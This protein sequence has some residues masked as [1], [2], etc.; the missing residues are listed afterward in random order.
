MSQFMCQV[1]Y[2]TCHVSRDMC[3]MPRITCPLSLTPTAR[4]TDP[5]PYANISGTLFDQKSSVHREAGFPRWYTHTTHGHQNL[6]SESAQWTMRCWV[7]IHVTFLQ[8]TFQVFTSNR[9]IL[10]HDTALNITYHAKNRNNNTINLYFVL[11]CR[12]DILLSQQLWISNQIDKS[13]WYFLKTYQIYI[14]FLF[15]NI[16]LFESIYFKGKLYWAGSI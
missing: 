9:I 16:N 7:H 2:G 13:N 8:S 11:H 12:Y 14:F 4:A 3:C 5:P 6:E 10:R 1:S 15:F